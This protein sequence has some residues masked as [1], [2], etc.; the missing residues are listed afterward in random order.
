LLDLEE[1]YGGESSILTYKTQ[2]LMHIFATEGVC[3]VGGQYAFLFKTDADS[4]VDLSL[5]HN[6]VNSR[7][8]NDYVGILLG[9][10]DNPSSVPVRD[11]TSKRYISK[12]TYG[13]AN[14]PFYLSGK[15]YLLSRR[16]AECMA[17]QMATQKFMPLEDVATGLLAEDCT[18]AG[19]K[20]PPF[21]DDGFQMRSGYYH[22]RDLSKLHTA[23]DGASW[24][25]NVILRTD[26]GPGEMR[27]LS[28]LAGIIRATAE[29]AELVEARKAPKG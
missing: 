6:R 28:L 22:S 4:F 5:L 21:G 19:V 24:N 27:E 25:E 26:V 17:G 9:G 29:L 23:A 10:P 11:P 20:V 18:A 2:L 14:F 7:V 16:A 15:G 8:N 13:R 3:G 12:S 1:A